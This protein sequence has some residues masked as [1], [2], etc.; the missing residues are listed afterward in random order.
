MDHAPLS[1]AT[2]LRMNILF[3]PADLNDA[4]VLLVEE[5]GRNL[6]WNEC[7][8]PESLE[9][10]RFAALKLSEGQLDL[11]CDAVL[12]AQTDWRDLLMCAGFACR[13]DEHL[14]WMP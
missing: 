6:C 1:P 10:V 2:R 4:E 5:C 12:L 7:A 3:A 13:L 14:K 11:L 8:T 9:R